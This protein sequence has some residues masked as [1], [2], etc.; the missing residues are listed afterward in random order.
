L[1]AL[2]S[3]NIKTTV[4]L[5]LIVEKFNEQFVVTYQC[6]SKQIP[7]LQHS[8]NTTIRQFAWSQ[9]TLLWHKLQFYTVPTIT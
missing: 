9:L 5:R 4:S 2:K 8:T 7:A 3:K 6:V 1:T